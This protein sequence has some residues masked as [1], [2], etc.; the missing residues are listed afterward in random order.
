M[1][2]KLLVCSLVQKALAHIPSDIDD[3]KDKKWTCCRRL[4]RCN[5]HVSYLWLPF[6]GKGNKLRFKVEGYTKENAKELKES[7]LGLPGVYNVHIHA[8]NGE[9]TINY[10]PAKNHR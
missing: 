4:R 5:F 9:T 8:H 6:G 7:L 2:V 10:N 1:K 3:L